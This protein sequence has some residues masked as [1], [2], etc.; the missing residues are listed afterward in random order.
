MFPLASEKYFNSKKIIMKKLSSA[1][2]N[3]KCLLLILVSIQVISCEKFLDAKPDQAIAEPTSAE[4]VQRLLDGYVTMNIAQPN[5]GMQSDDDFYITDVYYNSLIPF[6]KNTYTWEKDIVTDAPWLAL[7][8]T[9]LSSNLSLEVLQQLTGPDDAAYRRTL[10]AQALYYRSMAFY[11]LAQVFALP[12]EEAVAAQ[13]PGIC[14]R[15]A[16]DINT[17]VVR[18]SMKDTYNKIITDLNNSLIALPSSA[19]PVSRPSKVAG[20]PLMSNVYLNMRKY[21]LAGL[22]ADSALQLNNALIDYNSIAATAAIPFTQ[23][24]K[25]I[26]FSAAMSG[27]ARFNQTNMKVDS[28]LYQ[29]Y[30]IHDLRKK[31]YFRQSGTTTQFGFKGNYQG[32]TTGALFTGF[33]TAEMF[34][35]RAESAARLGLK[36]SALADLNRLMQYRFSV[37]NFVPFTAANAGDALE[38]ILTERRKELI[39]RGRRWYDLRRLNKEPGW[40]INLQRKIEGQLYQLP[41]NDARYVFAIP[42]QVVA[43]HGVP[44]NER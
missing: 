9:V 21:A 18:H 38:I 44:Q 6:Y 22:Y 24:N 3:F 8:K 14:I 23:F 26:I 19:F 11:Q 28:V 20:Y 1:C 33:T 42:L 41:A 4:D 2:R 37:N 39:G 7:Y 35:I 17:P 27:N 13:T 43:A 15:T 5:L 31:L 36:D 29:S 40:E 30:T 12:Y 34:L 16:S 25:E 10:A 32:N